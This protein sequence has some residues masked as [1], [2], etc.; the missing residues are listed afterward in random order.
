MAIHTKTKI[1]FTTRNAPNTP[2]LGCQQGF[3]CC[4]K[5]TVA[6]VQL[7][8][9]FQ[10]TGNTLAVNELF[11]ARMSDSSCAPVN[12]LL[13]PWETKAAPSEEPE[14]VSQGFPAGA[15]PSGA[16]ATGA[17]PINHHSP[18]FII[19]SLSHLFMPCLAPREG[20]RN[21]WPW[22]RWSHSASWNPSPTPGV[23][24]GSLICGIIGVCAI[25]FLWNHSVFLTETV[26]LLL[27]TW[28][29]QKMTEYGSSFLL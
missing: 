28:S 3:L 26:S 19:P 17:R 23:S 11:F 10:G 27:L 20:S 7:E 29:C 18:K 4:W 16:R 22:L 2:S 25:G 9:L 24:S 8:K 13:L 12:S 6:L 15:A 14:E 21:V 5:R 1:I